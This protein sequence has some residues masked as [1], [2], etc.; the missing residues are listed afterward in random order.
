ML[1]FL[2]LGDMFENNFKMTGNDFPRSSGRVRR[3]LFSPDEANICFY[4]FAELNNDHS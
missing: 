4:S 3:L 1:L 2:Y